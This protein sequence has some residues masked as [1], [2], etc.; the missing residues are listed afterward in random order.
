[1]HN[2]GNLGSFASKP[3]DYSI[4]I[5]TI[6]FM[7]QQSILSFFWQHIKPYKWY[8]LVMVSAPAIS[9][10]YPFAYNYAIKLFLDTMEVTGTLTYQSILFPIILFITAQIILEIVW[11][12]SSIA[13]WM[14][15]PYVRRSIL[16]KSYDY[17]QHHSYRF[18]QSNFI[19]AISSK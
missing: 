19:G 1:M 11:R 2:K 16:L 15:E 17:V 6:P 13:E 9:A 8:Y 12:T 14:S 10:F 5:K 3:L 4:K 18:F 7:Q